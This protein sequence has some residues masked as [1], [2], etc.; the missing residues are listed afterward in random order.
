[1]STEVIIILFFC[2]S[3]KITCQGCV[4]VHPIHFFCQLVGT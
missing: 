2:K 1:V 3:F 4:S